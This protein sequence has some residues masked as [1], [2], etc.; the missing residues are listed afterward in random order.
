[1]TVSVSKFDTSISIDEYFLD[2]YVG[3]NDAIVAELDPDDAG[4]LTYTSSNTDVVTVDSEGN[5]V[6]VGEKIGQVLLLV[7]PVLTDIRL[8][9]IL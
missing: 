4:E 1:M 2:M 9:Q 6:A 8:L 3:D 5:V 7:L